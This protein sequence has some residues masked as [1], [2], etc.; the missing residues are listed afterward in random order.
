LDSNRISYHLG[1]LDFA[2]RSYRISWQKAF[3]IAATKIP[4]YEDL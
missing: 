3:I 2:H 4:E 1:Y